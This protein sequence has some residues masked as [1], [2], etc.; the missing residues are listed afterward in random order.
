MEEKK[1]FFRVLTVSLVLLA[2]AFILLF[3][4]VDTKW[5]N[6]RT[7]VI[8]PIHTVIATVVMLVIDVGVYIKRNKS[9]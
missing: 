7:I 6:F 4:Y 5:W 2:A 3:V 1:I 8:N 9:N